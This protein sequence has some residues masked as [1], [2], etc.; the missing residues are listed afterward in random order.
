VCLFPLVACFCPLLCAYP[1]LNTQTNK[2]TTVTTDPPFATETSPRRP[3]RTARDRKAGRRRDDDQNLSVLI[4]KNDNFSLL[5]SRSV[6]LHVLLFSRFRVS[7][8]ELYM[9]CLLSEISATAMLL[10]EQRAQTY[11]SHRMGGTCKTGFLYNQDR[12]NVLRTKSVFANF[13]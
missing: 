12:R 3:P 11:R 1:L 4:V 5:F 10:H 8:N 9:N 6:S 2:Q 7:C 13:Y